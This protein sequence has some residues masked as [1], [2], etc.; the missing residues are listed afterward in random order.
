MVD[1]H[2][3]Y[4]K[5][6]HITLRIMPDG[7]L[8]VTAP[9]R[10]GKAAIEDVIARKQH[11]ILEHQKKAELLKQER[12][13]ESL[14]NGYCDGGQIA[15]LG[16]KYPLSATAEGKR[17]WNWDGTCLMLQGCAT[18]AQ[19]RQMVEQFYRHQMLQEIIPMLQQQVSE[20]LAVLHL[21]EAEIKV[22]KMRSSWGICYSQQNKIVLNLWLAMAPPEC[23]RQVMI[24]EYLHFCQND[25][26]SA[27]YALLQQ[28]EPQYRQL[29]HRLS[30]LVDL[31]EISE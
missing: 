3:T 8:E 9:H 30:V 19:C 17:S 1:Y 10:T 18:E 14:H 2:V 5:V 24:H 15:Y 22:R 13:S 29:K 20:I 28:F 31:T 27:F 4:K 7:K 6:K 26:S 21:P 11:W 23:I 12:S 25:H 16:R